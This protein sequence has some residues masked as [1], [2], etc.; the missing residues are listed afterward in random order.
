LV[1]RVSQDGAGHPRSGDESPRRCPARLRRTPGHGRWQHEDDRQLQLQPQTSPRLALRNRRPTRRQDAVP[2]RW[3]SEAMLPSKR[4]HPTSGHR[5]GGHVIDGAR[6]AGTRGG[7][8][9]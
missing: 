8:F 6:A 9:L 4:T 2:P 1:S 3:A 5:R 7:G